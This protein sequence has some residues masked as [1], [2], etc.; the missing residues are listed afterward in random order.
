M[1]N[2]DELENFYIGL[3]YPVCANIGGVYLELAEGIK[4][5]LY[6]LDEDHYVDINNRKIGEVLRKNKYFQSSFA[7]DEDGLIPVK[8]KWDIVKNTGF[9]KRI[10]F[11]S[12]NYTHK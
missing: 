2:Y 5:I 12:S 4:T 1:I 3:A 11:N 7:I 10:S 8:T 9:T 6:K